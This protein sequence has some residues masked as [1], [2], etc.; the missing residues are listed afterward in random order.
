M[1]IKMA[2]GGRRLGA[3]LHHVSI[4]ECPSS[5]RRDRIVLA[6]RTLFPA[7]AE[8]G[9]ETGDELLNRQIEGFADSQQRKNGNRSSG[10]DHLP[11]AHAE[12]VEDHVLLA[13]ATLRSV[14]PNPVPQGGR[15]ARNGP[16]GLCWHPHFQGL[17]I[18]EQNTTSKTAF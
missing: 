7:F 4:S 14:G 11:V 2:A 8:M 18:G 9:R 10:L 6:E 13:Q 3:G 17:F 1:G 5:R 15:S 16:A 12:A